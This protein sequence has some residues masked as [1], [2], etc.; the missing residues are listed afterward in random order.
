MLAVTFPP[1][2]MMVAIAQE[3]GSI[4]G[5]VAD[6]SG[7]VIPGATVTLTNSASLSVAATTDEQGAYSFKALGAGTYDVTVFLQGFKIFKSQGFVLAAGQ[8]GHLDVTLQ[9]AAAAASVTVTGN[10]AAQVET[11]NSTI[12]GTITEKEITSV[13]LNGRNFTQLITL[14]PGVSNQTGQDEALVGVKGSVKY[15]VNG[16]RVEYNTF[17]ID[18]SDVLNAGINGSQSTLIVYPSLDALSEVKV[19]TSNY[20]AMYGRTASG[21]VL[22]TTKSGGSEFHGDGYE[23]IRN[24]FFNAR[25]FFDQT[26]KAPLYRRNDFGGTI[27]GPIYIPGH[28]NTE[29]NKTFFF[30]SEE[31]RYEKTPQDF[32][33]A[34]PSLQER[35]GNFSDVCPFAEPGQNGLPGQQVY[36]KRSAYPDCPQQAA[37]STVGYV[38]TYPGN[39]IPISSNAALLLKTGVI[40][41]PTSTTGCN[42]TISSCYDAVISPPTYWREELFRIDQNF[43]QNTRLTFRYIHDEWNTITATPQWPYVQNSFPTIQNQ[44][45]GPGIDMVAHLFHIFTPTFV[46]DV[47]FSNSTDHITLTDQNGPGATYIRPPGLTIGYLF[48]NGFG[49]KIPGIIIAGNNAAYGGNGFAVDPSYEPWHHTNPTYT[50]ADGATKVIGKHT[51]QFGTSFIIAQRNQINNASGVNSGDVQGIL[52]FD[53]QSSLFTSGNAFA[54]FLNGG[55]QTFQQESAQ[56]KYYQRYNVAEP[57]LQ[58]DW[59]VTSRLTLN[60]GLRISLFGLWHEKYNNVYNWD[61]AAFNPANAAQVDTLTGVLLN[62]TTQQPIP[63]NVNNVNPSII[64]GIVECGTGSIPQGCMTNHLVNPA[65][66]IGFAWDPF[67]TGKTSVRGGYGI[68][69]EHGTGYEANTGSLEGSPPVVLNMTQYFPFGYQ[70][71]GG[72]GAGCGGQGAYPLNVNSIPTHAVWPYVQQWSLS[73]Q[74]ELSKNFVGSVAYVGS[75]GTHLTAALQVNQLAPLNPTNN[76]FLPGEAITSAICNTYDGASFLLNGNMLTSNSPGFVNLEAA[77]YGTP[78]K[79]FPNVNSLREYAPG[80]GAIYSLQN[81]ADSSY[82]ALQATLRRVVGPLLLNVAYTYSHSLDD[83]SDRFDSTFVNAYNLRSN[84]ASSNFDQ[85]NLLNMSYVYDFSLLPYVHRLNHLWN[86]ENRPSA[87]PAGTALPQ[88]NGIAGASG[89]SAGGS[90]GGLGFWHTVLDNWEW[91]G[92]STYQSGIPFSVINGASGANGV[93]V[94]DNAGVANGIGPASYPDFIGDPYSRGPIVGGNNPK[95]FGPI[96]ANPDAFV[97]PTGLTFGDAGRNILNNPSRLNFDMAL[98]KHFKT[99]EKTT[100]ELRAEAFNIFNHPQFEIYNPTTGNA[101][102]NTVSCYGGPNNSAG[103][104]GGGVNCLEGN[105]FLHAIDSHRPRTI[106]FGAKFFF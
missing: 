35:S 51:V 105:S 15:S 79:N 60:V 82:N 66:R 75:K 96:L 10:Q 22:A 31:L 16:G 86:W 49:G 42:S 8:A 74:R 102:N 33:Q 1:V 94:L 76:P 98:L 48:N 83:S 57:Y 71:I 4:S 92:I 29:K 36:F 72:V 28:Y 101:A 59:R 5:T 54:D 68:F 53:N 32:N 78:G 99:S 100:V 61:P 77:C 81:V 21:T 62:P 2:F 90:L 13:G 38:L 93:S 85:R 40:P 47:S 103:F 55:I 44:F 104:V 14:T 91:T 17:D 50:I 43:T 37:S 95:S 19:L 97:A 65:P 88:P 26:P 58:D 69:Y 6:N 30:F 52:T 12:A 39:Q 45:A 89:G 25:N 34:V 41:P 84:W 106:Q 87:D 67:G 20:G 24:E 3:A 64:N 11:E 63:I 80:L 7:G 9:P 46:N 70:C 56:Y 27:G 73:V 18:G 23:F